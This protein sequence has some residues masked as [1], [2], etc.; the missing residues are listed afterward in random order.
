MIMPKPKIIF[1]FTCY[2]GVETNDYILNIFEIQRYH[3][4]I[5]NWGL[6]CGSHGEESDC[7]VEDLG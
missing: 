3:V 7:S 5:I 2:A 4:L 6:P 1:M